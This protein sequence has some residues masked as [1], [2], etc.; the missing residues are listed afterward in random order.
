MYAKSI[1]I[2]TQAKK[3]PFI[4][5]CLKKS[6]RNEKLKFV[7]LFLTES[8]AVFFSFLKA[9]IVKTNLYIAEEIYFSK[10]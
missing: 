8:P 6:K 3:K 10:P 7:K 9:R 4:N 5:L 1:H 2:D